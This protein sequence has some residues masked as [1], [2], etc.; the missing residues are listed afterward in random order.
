MPRTTAHLAPPWPKGVSGNPSGRVK[1]DHHMRD[2][3][4]AHTGAAIKALVAALQNKRERV[5][6]AIALLDRGWGRPAQSVTV[7]PGESLEQLILR[8]MQPAALPMPVVEGQ[9]IEVEPEPD[10]AELL[11]RTT[12]KDG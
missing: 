2:L 6:A 1:T 10:P 4:R 3:A 5:P 12:E 7:A 8:A 11:R 9:V